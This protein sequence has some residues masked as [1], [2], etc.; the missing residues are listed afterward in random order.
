VEKK[1]KPVKSLRQ[2]SAVISDTLL[3]L[4][5]ELI[6]VFP[7]PLHLL[8]G[9]TLVDLGSNQPTTVDLI[10]LAPTATFVGIDVNRKQDCKSPPAAARQL[11]ELLQ[12]RKMVSQPLPIYAFWLGQARP[13]E[14]TD[15]TPLLPDAASIQQ[16]IQLTQSGATRLSSDTLAA[17]AKELLAQDAGL[18][19][20]KRS[21]ISHLRHSLHGLAGLPRRIDADLQGLVRRS[22]LFHRSG[23]VLPADANKHLEAAMLAEENVLEDADYGK[24]VP[25]EYVVELNGD[26]YQRNYLPIERQICDRW[27]TRLQKILDTTNQRW[28]RA[29]YRFG[30]QV[31]VRPRPAADL[32]ESQVRIWCQVNPN[33]DTAQA[34]VAIACLELVAG[35]R[36][37]SLQQERVTIGRDSDCDVHLDAPVVRETRL[38]SGQHAYIVHKHRGY[39]L[40]DGTLDGK[41]STNGTFVNGRP[42]GPEGCE[43]DDGN[44]IILAA[45]DPNQPRLET[46][47][48]AIFSFHLDC[49]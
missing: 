9:A 4:A 12:Q 25:N 1:G 7:D 19:E 14:H 38:V 31:Q 23:P 46:P 3:D 47:G 44:V 17:L 39:R 40:F 2:G 24:I 42:V 36:R 21:L 18:Q 8:I 11:A 32:A 34:T 13:G 48:V 29:A 45:L 49:G 33:L 27:Q 35:G 37:W 6:R 41:P 15:D 43:L 20:R 28:G 16:Y 5:Q 30:G 10:G 22:Y 26:N